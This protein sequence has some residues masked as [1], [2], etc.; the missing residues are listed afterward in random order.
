MVTLVL[1]NLL[2]AVANWMLIFGSFGA[3]ALGV[4]GAAW[5][6]VLSRTFM[7]GVLVLVVWTETGGI[8]RGDLLVEGRR[9]RTL[10]GLGLPAALQLGLEV[11]VFSIASALAGRMTA[12]ALAAHQIAL[13]L[14]SFTY[15]VPLGIASAGAVRVGHGI[16]RGD[17]AAAARSGWTAIGLGACFM[18]AAAVVFTALPRQLI[19]AFTADPGVLTVG[20]GLLAVAA[21]FQ[22]F[23]GLQAVATGALRGLGDTR[24]AMFWNLAGHWCIG[25]PVAYVMA[26]RLGWGITG[27]WWGLS[28]GL[29]VCGIALLIFWQRRIAAAPRLLA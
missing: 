24:T 19:G 8:R 23:D 14:A 5:A 13:N 21:V 1:A 28:S 4:V 2:N 22:L 17:V 20:V 18:T 29:V 26:F 12:S 16:G 6:T 27:L 9:L 7:A 11:G 10:T 3:P 15:M 25:L